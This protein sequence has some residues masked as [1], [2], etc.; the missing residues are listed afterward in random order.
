MQNTKGFQSESSPCLA[1]PC[2]TGF[3]S[4]SNETSTGYFCNCPLGYEG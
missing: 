3:C 2:N 1:T 4:E